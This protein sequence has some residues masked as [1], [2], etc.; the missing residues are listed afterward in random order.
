V[1]QSLSQFAELLL[2]LDHVDTLVGDRGNNARDG[3]DTSHD[4]AQLC[5]EVVEGL[6]ETESARERAK[7]RK[8]KRE[9]RM[10]G[11][12]E[13]EKDSERERE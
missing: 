5:D 3:E 6:V 1:L 7:E 10:E 2:L 9:R 4:G 13:R 11:G 12:G 8:R